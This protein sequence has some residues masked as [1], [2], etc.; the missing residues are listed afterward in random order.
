MEIE[1]TTTTITST[2]DWQVREKCESARARENVGDYE[3]ARQALGDLW[4]VVGERP[5]LD[6]LSPESEAEL[7][8]QVGTLTGFLGSVQQI[9]VAQELAKDLISE[10]IRRLEMIEDGERLAEAHLGLAICYWREGGMDEARVCLSAAL[11]RG[12][13]PATQL[14]ILVDST[15]PEIST[16]HLAEALTLL[17]QAAPLLDT[18][19]DDAAKGRYHMQ[20]A[21]T[22][23]RLGGIENLDRALIENTAAAFHFE[24]AGHKRYLARIENNIGSLLLQFGRQDEALAHLERSRSTFAFLKDS[25]SVAQVNETRA[26]AFLAKGRNSEGERAAFSAVTVL[27]RGGESAL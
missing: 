2:R 14:R 3:G 17:D 23:K 21:L 27:E 7:L 5:L 12:T 18:V 8:L 25:G 1:Q 20:R 11:T 9:A 4:T 26:R 22:L 19:T 15:L 16:N 10:S 13:K 6:D 24:Q